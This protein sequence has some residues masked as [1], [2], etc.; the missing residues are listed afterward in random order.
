MRMKM[1]F[2]NWNNEMKFREKVRV[3]YLL[4]FRI[5]VIPPLYSQILPVVVSPYQEPY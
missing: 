1:T 5:Y 4:D 3:I 2:R